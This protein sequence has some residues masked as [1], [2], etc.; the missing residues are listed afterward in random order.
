MFSNPTP[1]VNEPV[2]ITAEGYH[3]PADAADISFAG[4][5]GA[6]LSIA[7]DGSSLTFLPAPGTTG[8]ALI[9]QHRDQL[10]PSDAAVR[11]LTTAE[12]AVA[13]LVPL[14]GTGAPGTAPPLTVPPVG[15]TSTFFDGGTYDYPAPIF[16]GAFGNFPAR[17]YSFTV[18]T[19]GATRSRW[20]G[21]VGSRI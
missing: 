3:L 8:P 2:T 17:L 1:A 11:S 21:Q 9:E 16:G 15:E 6:D 20:I 5:S 7:E 19:D 12:L 13:E 10:P 14:A 18:P 4:D